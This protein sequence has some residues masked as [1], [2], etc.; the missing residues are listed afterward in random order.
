MS[1][2]DK[3]IIYLTTLAIIT[4][5]ISGQFRLENE[6]LTSVWIGVMSTMVFIMFLF[7]PRMIRAFAIG[8]NLVIERLG[9]IIW[10]LLLGFGALLVYGILAA[11]L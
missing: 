8:F 7:R 9:F 10:P 11:V 4:M 3:Q 6:T 2:H 1:K 5:V